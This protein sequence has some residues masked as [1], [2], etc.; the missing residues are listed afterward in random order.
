MLSM[1]P[2][3]GLGACKN[4]RAGDQETFGFLAELAAT[5]PL[6]CSHDSTTDDYQL[7][8]LLFSCST[9]TASLPRPDAR[10]GGNSAAISARRRLHRAVDL[11]VQIRRG[12]VD[13]FRATA[14]PIEDHHFGDGG[15]GAERLDD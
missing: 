8:F 4:R 12:A 11:V 2:W 5:A 14:R 13:D 15:D 3:A 6:H 10:D 9:A 1:A 7:L